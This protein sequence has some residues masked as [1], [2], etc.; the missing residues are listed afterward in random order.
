M[1]IFVQVFIVLAS[2][3]HQATTTIAIAVTAVVVIVVNIF[4]ALAYNTIN[5]LKSRSTRR[6][7][8]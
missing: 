5:K 2:P 4:K 8:S 1:Y 3:A 6:K 7:K